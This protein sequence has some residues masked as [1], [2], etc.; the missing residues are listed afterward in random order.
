MRERILRNLASIV[1]VFAWLTGCIST[2]GVAEGPWSRGASMPT[3][4][5]EIAVTQ[6]DSRIYVAGGIGRLGTTNAF[7]VYD[8][9]TNTWRR[10]AP[11]PEAAHHLAMTAASGRIY[12]SGGYGNMLFRPDRRSAWVYEPKT[13]VWQPIADMPGPRAAHKLVTLGGKIYAVGG[14]GPDSTALWVYDPET[15]RWDTS[16]APLPTAREHLAAVAAAGKLYGIAGRWSGRGNLTAVPSE[17]PIRRRNSRVWPNRGKVG[18]CV[19]P[20]DF[21]P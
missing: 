19:M 10:L 17:N 6:L 16:R 9:S 18:V 21:C 3:A 5:S 13:D 11:L 4:R 1:L 2:P 20:Y 12:V 14:V 7:E 8:A 15:A